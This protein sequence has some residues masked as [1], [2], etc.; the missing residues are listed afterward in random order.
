MEE[1]FESMTI[2]MQCM[3]VFEVCMRL[4]VKSNKQTLPT[5]PTNPSNEQCMPQPPVQTRPP[6]W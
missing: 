5:T 6:S 4:R 1:V 3:Y 2:T